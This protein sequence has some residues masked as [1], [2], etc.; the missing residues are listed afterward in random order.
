MYTTLYN[1]Y[2]KINHKNAILQLQLQQPNFNQDWYVFFFFFFLWVFCVSPI[3]AVASIGVGCLDAS[4]I[5]AKG[6]EALLNGL[7]VAIGAL[8]LIGIASS[9]A[10]PITVYTVNR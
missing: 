5:A 3:F 9:H 4:P 10:S 8:A 6:R 1:Q 2:Y 7:S